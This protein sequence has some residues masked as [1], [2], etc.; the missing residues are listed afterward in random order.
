M[1]KKKNDR[2]FT[3]IELMIVIAVIG[4]L[5]VVLAPKMTSVKDSAKTTGVIANART[6]EA[7]IVANIDQW[8][9]NSSVIAG[10][11]GETGKV[12]IKSLLEGQFVTSNPL[13]NPLND[14]NGADAIS[15]GQNPTPAEGKVTVTITSKDLITIR[16]YGSSG[17]DLIFEAEVT[18]N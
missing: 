2:G 16:G 9:K 10:D 11:S 6:V 17:T 1:F 7:Y 14:K 18:P 3:L 12:T 5:A 4:I 13:T 8:K 15:I